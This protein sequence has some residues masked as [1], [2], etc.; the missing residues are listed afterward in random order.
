MREGEKKNTFNWKII[1]IVNWVHHTMDSISLWHVDYSIHHN[2]FTSR[3]Q[4]MLFTRNATAFPSV[5]FYFSSVYFFLISF[6]M[7]LYA[8]VSVTKHPLR[9]RSMNVNKIFF[10]WQHEIKQQNFQTND[11][12]FQFEKKRSILIW[13]HSFNAAVFLIFAWKKI[14]QN[15]LT[16]LI[17]AAVFK[18]SLSGCFWTECDVV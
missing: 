5:R 2:L 10:S 7:W 17:N 13:C 3:M 9:L 8:P 11:S 6:L 4:E 16:D 18:Q 1:R 14:A 15:I 12:I